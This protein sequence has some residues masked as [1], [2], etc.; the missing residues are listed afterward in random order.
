MSEENNTPDPAPEGRPSAVDNMTDD[1]IQAAFPGQ[2]VAHIRQMANKNAGR[3]EADPTPDPV[4]YP[5]YIPE[6]YRKGTLEESYMAMASALSNPSAADPDPATDPASVSVFAQSEADFVKD[7]TISDATYEAA[8]AK[9]INKEEL[10][11]YLAGRVAAGN[12]IVSKAHEEAG[13]EDKYDAMLQW[14]AQSWTEVQT[15]EYDKAMASGETQRILMAVKA[16]KAEYTAAVGSNP[17]LWANG[18]GNTPTIL[19][20][21]SKAEMT[22][23][24]K[25]PKYKTDPAYREQVKQKIKAGNVWGA[26]R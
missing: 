17:S 25:D 26:R 1:Q 12:Q 10:D 2:D 23:A 19:G 6:Q 24:M 4:K 14:A 16:L 9:G 22:A 15:A 8:Q 7:G 11:S 13:G 18:D 3:P 20:F 5:D 21:Q